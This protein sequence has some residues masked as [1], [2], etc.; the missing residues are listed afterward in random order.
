MLSLWY[1]GL[2][3]CTPQ[4]GVSEAAARALAAKQQEQVQRE[5]E[6]A[7]EAAARYPLHTH[8]QTTSVTGHSRPPSSFAK[9]RA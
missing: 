3:V 5:L 9:S 8:T 1:V 2:F 7:S 4:L 6:L